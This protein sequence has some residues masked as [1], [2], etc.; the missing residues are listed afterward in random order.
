MQRFLEESPDIAALLD[1]L[2]A[3]TDL[4]GPHHSRTVAVA[5]KLAIALWHA[6]DFQGAV[7]L[8]NRALRSF[9]LS[10]G[11]NHPAT[12]AAKGDLAAILFELGREK[13]AGSLELEA[14]ESARIHLGKTHSVTCVL[15]WNRA[16]NCERS[17]DLDAA[18]RVISNEL[19]W[20]LTEDSSR[21]HQ[22]QNIIRVMLVE[23]LNWNQATTC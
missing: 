3:N 23:R 7:A 12:L 8:L 20:L 9:T 16:L 19:T 17:G 18:R 15:A 13:E 22:D 5:H 11:E 21:L 2:E 6:N 14:L 10:L 4:F 1:A